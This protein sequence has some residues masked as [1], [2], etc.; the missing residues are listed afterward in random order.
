MSSR[1]SEPYLLSILKVTILHYTWKLDKNSIFFE[2]LEFEL[3]IFFPTLVIDGT[4]FNGLTFY[5]A[6]RSP[7]NILIIWDSQN[8]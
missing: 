3:W 6:N 5:S 2:N 4:I 8:H 7:D 1:L